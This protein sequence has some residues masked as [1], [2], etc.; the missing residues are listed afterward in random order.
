MQLD[1]KELYSIKKSIEKILKKKSLT[2]IEISNSLLHVHRCQS[3]FLLRYTDS[4]VP[5]ANFL[6]KAK[7]TQSKLTF[8]WFNIFS[9]KTEKKP[10]NSFYDVLIISHFVSKKNNLY[11]KDFYFAQ[12]IDSLLKKD[13]KIKVVYIDDADKN[14]L[15]NI[16]DKNDCLSYDILSNKLP[17]YRCVLFLSGIL[18]QSLIYRFISLISI[19]QEKKQFYRIISQMESSWTNLC[20]SYKIGKIV[21]ADRP[22]FLFTTFEG[23]AYE[24]L[25]YFYSKIFCNNIVRVGY[26]HAAI[27]EHQ[28]SVKQSFGKKFDPDLILTQGNFSSKILSKVYNKVDTGVIAVGAPR[29]IM[30][31]IENEKKDAIL[32]IP[33]GILTEVIYLLEFSIELSNLMPEFTI[34]FR[35]HP[36]FDLKLVHP[37]FSIKQLPSNFIISNQ[38]LESDS[39]LCKFTLYRDSTAIFNAVALGSLPIYIRKVDE[40]IL[41]NPIYGISDIV[42]EIYSPIEFK[43]KMDFLVTL[44]VNLFTCRIQDIV[45]NYQENSFYNAIN[46]VLPR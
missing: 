46:T 12:I 18:V 14:I 16:I 33:S 34:H 42:P 28:F 2:P 3:D 21:K 36:S 13:Y 6:E 19:N 44:D 35:F 31:R 9:F 45:S 39:S 37:I 24:R 26:F 10:Y 38:S 43:R 25:I 15:D 30:Y 23:Q 27:F 40:E 29:T 8:S 7:K 32:V 17:I 20:T 41:V 11:Y 4:V 1:K 22:K 5:Q